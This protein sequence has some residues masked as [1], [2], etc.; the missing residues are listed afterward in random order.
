MKWIPDS[1]AKRAL[2]VGLM[3]S[4]GI[5][6]AS[7]YAM[8]AGGPEGKGG[9]EARQ[10]QKHDGQKNQ[11]A[12]EEKRSKHMAMLK[13]KLK[14]T[15]EQETAWNE[16]VSASQP[17]GRRMNADRQ[18]MRGEFENL[19]TPQR[20]DKMLAVSEAR[21]VSMLERAQAIKAFYGQLT[22]EQQVVFDAEAM[23]KRHQARQSHRIQS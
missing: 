13:D 2:I 11:A 21:R 19:N 8:S 9:C 15:P 23:P 5:L 16:F 14:L 6:A 22:P 18:A 10:M 12:R 20:L 3:A 1:F 7:A 4:G 17:E